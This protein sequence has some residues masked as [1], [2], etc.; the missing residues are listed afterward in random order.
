MRSTLPSI[1][2]TDMTQGE[3]H[4]QQ[5]EQQQQAA[6]LRKQ[7][8]DDMLGAAVLAVVFTGLFF[9]AQIITNY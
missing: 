4:Q 7:R 5:L 6:E 8:L 3:F 9:L 1:K 2:E